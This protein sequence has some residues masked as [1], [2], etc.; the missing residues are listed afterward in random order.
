MSHIIA[1]ASEIDKDIFVLMYEVI[2]TVST[3]FM[4]FIIFSSFNT[5]VFGNFLAWVG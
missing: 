2:A 1:A 4:L 3:H 5:V